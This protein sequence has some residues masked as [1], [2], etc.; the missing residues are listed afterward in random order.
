M[1]GSNISNSLLSEFLNA[2]TG[3]LRSQLGKKQF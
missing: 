2:V 3:T 1:S